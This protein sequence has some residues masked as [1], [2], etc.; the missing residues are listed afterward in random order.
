MVI[1]SSFIASLSLWLVNNKVRNRWRGVNE[2]YSL[3]LLRHVNGQM[4]VCLIASFVKIITKRVA[5]V[6]KF[7]SAR[8][9][10]VESLKV[11]WVMEYLLAIHTFDS[12]VLRFNPGLNSYKDLA[13]VVDNILDNN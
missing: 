6:Y 13:T 5:A 3:Y 1:L 4:H 2:L 9:A 7:K 8:M 12:I 10:S 11:I